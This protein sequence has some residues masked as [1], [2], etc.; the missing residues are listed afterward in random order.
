MSTRR[1]LLRRL[2]AGLVLFGALGG[3]GLHHHEDLAAFGADGSGER[4][5]SGHSPLSHSAH[6]HSAVVVKDD[7]C[8]ACQGQRS[9]GVTPEICRE[10]PLALACFH[11]TAAAPALR[12][13]AVESHGS[14][15]P[16]A[17]L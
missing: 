8:L 4:V 12:P 9:A 10:A 7:A 6:W 5:L 11:A 13:V 16:P 1:G 15:G 14:R 17:L 2:A 3:A